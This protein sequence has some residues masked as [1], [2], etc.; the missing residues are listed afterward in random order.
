MNTYEQHPKFSRRH[1]LAPCSQRSRKWGS[2]SGSNLK[3]PLLDQKLCILNEAFTIIKLTSSRFEMLRL[4][5]IL[6]LIL[7]ISRLK[8]RI[9]SKIRININLPNM[10]TTAIFW[11]HQYVNPDLLNKWWKFQ[12]ILSVRDQVIAIYQFY[13]DPDPYFRFLFR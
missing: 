13:P 10:I 3:M 9:K 12:Q 6:D 8:I 11:W 2:G 4:T 1:Q 5:L 7:I